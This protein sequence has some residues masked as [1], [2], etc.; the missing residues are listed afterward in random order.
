MK[1]SFGTKIEIGDF[2][3]D[4]L[5]DRVWFVED[6][7]KISTGDSKFKTLVGM[8]YNVKKGKVYKAKSK[9]SARLYAADC[10]KYTNL[11][12]VLKM[13]ATT[14]VDYYTKKEHLASE[15]GIILNEAHVQY[16]MDKVNDLLDLRLQLDTISEIDRKYNLGVQYV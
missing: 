6:I 12:A 8:L 13:Q 4:D 7:K 10:S 15:L 14:M 5:T 11:S 3:K 16:F 9:K 1:D 2:I